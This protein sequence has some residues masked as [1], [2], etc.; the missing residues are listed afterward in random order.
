MKKILLAVMISATFF[1]DAVRADESEKL[2]EGL[3]VQIAREME[4]M[5]KNGDGVASEA[6]FLD[7]RLA[8]YEEQQRKILGEIDAD[9]NGFIDE[10]EYVVKMSEMFGSALGAIKEAIEKGAR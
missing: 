5:D 9:M 10:D 3:R 1:V 4:Q 6:E 7:Y 2:K 8:M